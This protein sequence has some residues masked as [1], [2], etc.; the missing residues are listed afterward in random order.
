MRL[1][2]QINFEN[3]PINMKKAIAINLHS[4]V[5]VITNS[6]S[7]LFVCNTDKAVETVES[8]LREKLIQFNTLHDRNYVYEDCFDPVYIYTQEMHT[9]GGSGPY[10]HG[11]DYENQN[12]VGKLIIQSACDNTIPYDMFD[13]IE[14][15][16]DA[17]R[18]H[19]G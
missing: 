14:G 19:L 3:N 5:D 8:I 2:S 10:G 16:F 18:H 4:F 6:S 9:E 11:W 13:L 17:N 1:N 12:N 7:E 15:L